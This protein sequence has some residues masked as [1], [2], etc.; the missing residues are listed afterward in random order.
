MELEKEN[1]KIYELIENMICGNFIINNKQY[2]LKNIT[3]SKNANT[4]KKIK[5]LIG[6]KKDFIFTCISLQF[7]NISLRD[8]E[9][10]KKKDFLTKIMKLDIFT[11]ILKNVKEKNT[12]LKN[13]EKKLK[14]FI[15]NDIKYYET[16]IN[17]NEKSIN[18]TI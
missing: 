2:N 9:Q 13:D 18:Q 10:S 17:D 7:N 14:L 4:E 16:I 1:F 6:T 3:G 8:M 12:S 15:N 5:E 11:D